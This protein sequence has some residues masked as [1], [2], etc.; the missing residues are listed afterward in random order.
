MEKQ[1]TEGIPLFYITVGLLILIILVPQVLPYLTRDDDPRSNQVIVGVVD[2]GCGQNENYVK[3]YQTFTNT[4]YGYPTNEIT[5]YDAYG[6]GFLV[7]EII[8][9]LSRESSIYSA[10]VANSDGILTY[11]GLFA[12]IKWLVEEINVDIIN[13]S[14]GSEPMITELLQH[15]LDEYAN[16]TIFVASSGNTGSSTY[17][18]RG[19]GDW[20]A[21]LPWTI[22]VGAVADENGQIGAYYSASGRTLIGSFIAEF[23]DVG[24]YRGRSGTS[25]STPFITGK[26]AQLLNQLRDEGIKVNTNE[27]IA[28]LSKTTHGWG[29]NVFDE[30]IGWGIP[31][32]GVDLDEL[33]QPTIVINGY[34]EIDE[35]IRY[36]GEQWEVVW[37]INSYGMEPNDVIN[38]V[39]FSGNATDSVIKTAIENFSWGSLLSISF[40][41]SS[42]KGR[43]VLNLNNDYGN[44][45]T[46]QFEVLPETKG[47]ILLDHRFSINGFGHPY[48]EFNQLEKLL[49]EQSF[50]V[51]HE[52]KDMMID[53]DQYVAIIVPRFYQ[54]IDV[55]PLSFTRED[56]DDYTSSYIDYIQNGGSVMILTDQPMYTNYLEDMPLLTKLGANFTGIDISLSDRNVN[57]NNFSNSVVFDGV[58]NL[59]YLGGEVK[60]I[61]QSV[62]ELG[63]YREQIIGQTSVLQFYRSIGVEGELGLG[64]YIILGATNFVT[65]P[66]LTSLSGVGYERMI[67][68]FLD[69][70]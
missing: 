18:S 62:A 35:H 4:T 11:E 63:W 10:K 69:I 21:S 67:L 37:K 34:S 51:E 17:D 32:L 59:P 2:S 60:G 20:P 28:I 50:I 5:T 23:A 19:Y 53:L 39:L 52:H 15:G 13:L 70:L 26:I 41:A 54:K 42:E 3:E 47:R 44:S 49:R 64:S 31:D 9:N 8:H 25:F 55:Q 1:K 57:V 7:C 66:Y 46:Y 24:I 6:H 43:Y 61:N 40:N 12:A 56:L 65:N 29:T 27:I 38:Q 45:I 36:S 14:L 48:G 22:G 68:N 30:V 16:Q 33:L 58:G